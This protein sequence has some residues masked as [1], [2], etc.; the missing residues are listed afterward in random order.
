MTIGGVDVKGTEDME[1]QEEKKARS[2]TR[3]NGQCDSKKDFFP[4]LEKH[5]GTD[6]EV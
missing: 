6:E 3:I 1:N 2:E 4:V 5:L